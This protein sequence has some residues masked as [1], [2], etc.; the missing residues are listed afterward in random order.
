M[1][2]A[3]ADN[4]AADK[5]LLGGKAFNLS[6]LSRNGYAVPYFFTI[7]TTT[8]H[9]IIRQN[10][11]GSEIAKTLESIKNDPTSLEK[12]LAGLR[13]NI[14][15]MSLPE[16][17][18][19][20]VTEKLMDSRFGDNFVSVRSSVADEDSA[21]ASF[22]GQMDTFLFQKGS[23]HVL[24]SY[25]KCLASA[26]SDR[27]IRYRIEKGLDTHNI[28]AA[29]I[30]QVMI[31]GGKSGV[32]FTANP[33]NGRR[34]E[35]LI[36]ACYGLGEGLVSG[37]CN[38]DEYTYNMFTQKTDSKISPKDTKLIFDQ[39]AGRG[40]VE[41]D[42][43]KEEQDVACLE[44]SEIAAIGQLG[45]SISKD[46][47]YPQDI[48]WT[49]SGDK[50]WV[51]QTRPVTS[52]PTSDQTSTVW[53]NSNIQ[54]SYCGVT[55]PLTFSYASRAY[56]D[57]Y[58]QTLNA[59]KVNDKTQAEYSETINNLLGT[60]NGRVY[61]NINNWYVGL[62]LL[63]SF[64]TNKADME[65]MMGLEDPVDLVE[66][67]QLTTKEK[68]KQV[69]K[70]LGTLVSLLYHFS[71]IDGLVRTFTKN[72]TREY[73]SIDRTDLHR[74]DITQILNHLG[75]LRKTV[76][77]EWGTPIINDFYVM[78]M[79]GKVK[80]ALEK[81]MDGDVVSLQN[82]LMAG[83]EGIEST[84]PTKRLLS[85]CDEIRANP[86][87]MKLMTGED[88]SCIM[89]VLQSRH[90]GTYERCLR[91]IDDYGD[92]T[93]GELKLESITL[94]QDPSFMFAMIKN[95]LKRPDITVDSMG[96]K[97][98]A[99]RAE[100][101]NEVYAKITGLKKV[102]FKRDLKRL[103]KAVKF[104][105]SMRMSRTRI[106]GLVRDIYLEIGTQLAFQGALEDARDIF[107][108]TVQEVEAYVEGRSVTTNLKP[109]VNIRREEYD[110]YEDNEPA[111]HF[112]TN[113]VVYIGNSYEYVGKNLQD[114]DPNAEIVHG[115][116]CYPGLV[117]KNLRL[118]LKPDDE[119][120]L[121]GQILCTVRTDPGWAPLFPTAG[122][123]LVER[124]S[125][126]SHS[127]VVAR[128]LG[129]PAIVG[130]PGLTNIV[131]DGQLVEM[132]G[133]TGELVLNPATEEA[134]DQSPSLSSLED[135]TQESRT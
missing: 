83:E 15:E 9:D 1:I 59:M 84:E 82:K 46:L 16:E 2:L 53:D 4:H 60:I 67:S 122:G 110:S 68:L 47:L 71:K 107:Y 96:K 109:L 116:G 76:T 26:Y 54:E 3:D 78:M 36:N 80:R 49:I 39:K 114:V 85:I 118:I 44:A 97:E 21:N 58:S 133:A 8:F 56:A 7:P 94:R 87:L 66:D 32:M 11:L 38:G 111:H 69:P 40:T 17:L 127:A 52:L 10:N 112:T 30:V 119:M 13:K 37:L 70:L 43:A 99:L 33:T 64:N 48:E 27:A 20:A 72:F 121:N 125:I 98:K 93:M 65:A 75:R 35:A 79:N 31:D 89:P 128:E 63:P 22:A 130:I 5:K 95:F 19:R 50:I 102:L 12:S 124:G 42:V 45:R 86:D 25:L 134:K 101:E 81:H 131:K 74:M 62:K 61:Y 92:R 123:L 88:N 104:R 51:L 108:L 117:R 57:V 73:K 91:Y 106:F 34:D 29:V 23:E 18:V 120:D 103:R 55:L 132:N 14:E 41:V 126:L 6:W 135:T 77:G 115:T 129:I 24:K 28:S 113:S 90:P 100:G 105:E